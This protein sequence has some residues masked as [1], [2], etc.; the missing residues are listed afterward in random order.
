MIQEQLS[1]DL[2]A[3]MKAGDKTRLRAI[4]SLS[5]ALKEREIEA[6][7]KGGGA[8]SQE[9]AAQVV[10]KQAKQRRDSIEQFEQANR[11]DLVAKEQ[12]E[13]AIIKEYLP[14]QMSDDEVRAVVRE[15]IEER[16]AES[17]KDLGKVMG[18]SVERTRGRADG[19]RVNEIARELLSQRG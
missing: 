6:R 1:N 2:K 17:P 13:L 12:E 19:K 8:L 14:K 4:R 3:A 9:E 18:P 5:A 15:V 7:T 16:G 10:Q 11:P